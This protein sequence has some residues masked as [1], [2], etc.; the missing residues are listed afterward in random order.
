MRTHSPP[1]TAAPCDKAN[2][3]SIVGL[4]GLNHVTHSSI[5]VGFDDDPGGAGP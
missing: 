2:G 4:A 3:F 1:H 5:S